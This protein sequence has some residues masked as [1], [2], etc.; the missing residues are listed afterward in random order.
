MFKTI[1]RDV[2]GLRGKAARLGGPVADA[3]VFP[4]LSAVVPQVVGCEACIF[5]ISDPVTG[6]L[7][8]KSASGTQMEPPADSLAAQVITT[9]RPVIRG[10]VL[11]H[12]ILS[13]DGEQVTGALELF[14]KRD[15]TFSE[16][17]LAFAERLARHV[18]VSVEQAFLFEETFTAFDRFQGRTYRLLTVTLTLGA[19]AGGLLLF[20]IAALLTTSG[21]LGDLSRFLS[22]L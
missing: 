21:V 18:A 22:D 3:D 15:G 9:R 5:H 17:D 11:C 20:Q 4:F 10:Q 1:R 16:R 7:T 2:K 6:A 19:M 12:P 13:H 8:L 14:N